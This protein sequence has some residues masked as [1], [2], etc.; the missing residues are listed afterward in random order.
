M[1]K[2]MRNTAYAD[3]KVMRAITSIVL[4][5]RI[6]WGGSFFRTW[7]KHV[8]VAQPLLAECVQGL[9]PPAQL[10]QATISFGPPD[11]RFGRGL[12]RIIPIL[13]RTAGRRWVTGFSPG[14]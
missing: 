3:G 9:V 2:N 12:A 14:R 10:V 1:K 7:T 13:F 11:S 4:A 8:S 6:G 5:T